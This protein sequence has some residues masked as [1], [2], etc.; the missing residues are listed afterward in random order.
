MKQMQLARRLAA[1]CVLGCL[2]GLAACGDVPDPEVARAEAQTAQRA[3]EAPAARPNAAELA[4]LEERIASLEQRKSRIEDARSVKRLQRAYGYYVDEALWDEVADLFAADATLEIGL[5]GVYAGPDRIREY[6]YTLG[7]GRSGLEEGQI[8]EHM[9]L[10]PVI[11]VAPDGMTAQGRWRTIMMLGEHGGDALWGEGPYENEYVKEDGVWKIQRLHWYQSVVVP[12]EDGWQ[13]NEDV[14]QGKW[15]SDELPP[16]GP[17][18]VE[19]ATWPGTYLPP[20]HFPNP[21]TGE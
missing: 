2:A 18:S 6:L 15:V 4:A 3:P 1:G 14:N 8:N 11:T 17:P 5:D 10:M 13:D 9:Q 16:D 12:Y 21:V 19:Y 7:N 20:F